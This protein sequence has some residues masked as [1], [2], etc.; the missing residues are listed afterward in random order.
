M[1]P[2]A[3]IGRAYDAGDIVRTHAMRPTWHFL[4]PEDLRWVE[5]L[6]G[7]RVLRMNGSLQRRLGIEVVLAQTWVI[8]AAVMAAPLSLSAE[9]GS[10]RFWKAWLR[11]WAMISA[12]SS[13]YHCR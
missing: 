12:V 11:P 8:S 4:A 6:T 1:P 2:M 7:D 3:D 5:A 10:P 9:R 13:R